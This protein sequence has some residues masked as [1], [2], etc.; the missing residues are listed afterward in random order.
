MPFVFLGVPKKL[1]MGR[2]VSPSVATTCTWFQ[3]NANSMTPIIVIGN[4][5]PRLI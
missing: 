2:K 3:Q 5:V 1:V 4:N